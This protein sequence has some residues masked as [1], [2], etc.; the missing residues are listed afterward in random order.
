M[1]AVRLTA[2]TQ[3]P[4]ITRLGRLGHHP[5]R[6]RQRDGPVRARPRAL[7]PRPPLA[8]D[9]EV[10]RPRRRSARDD[11]PGRRHPRSAAMDPGLRAGGGSPGAGNATGC[12]SAGGRG[13]RAQAGS[14]A[15]ATDAGT[16]AD[17]GANALAL[18]TPGG[19]AVVM[20]RAGRRWFSSAFRAP[21]PCNQK[22]KGQQFMPLPLFSSSDRLR[23]RKTVGQSS[24]FSSLRGVNFLTVK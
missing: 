12:A 7:H 21:C 23:E 9:P 3:A 18:Q 2:F 14:A 15:A 6:H 13:P 17:V 16:S 11:A 4:R 1:T 5:R 8:P 24:A 20:R 10:P 19:A 22:R